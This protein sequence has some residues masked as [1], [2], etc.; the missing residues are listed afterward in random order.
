MIQNQFR[1][2]QG[3]EDLDLEEIAEILEG[4]ALDE[5][6]HEGRILRMPG[7]QKLQVFL[8]Q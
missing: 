6:C 4:I 8:S 1:F 7:L 2:V 5:V 3:G